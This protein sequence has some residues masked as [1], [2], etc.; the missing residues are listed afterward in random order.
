MRGGERERGKI[1]N[2]VP[3]QKKTAEPAKVEPKKE[4]KEDD[5]DDWGAIPAFLRR[6]RLK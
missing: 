2:S 6:S 4:A 1:F 3:E 5:D